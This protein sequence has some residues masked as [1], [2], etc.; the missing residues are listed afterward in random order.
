MK[1]NLDPVIIERAAEAL[2]VRLVHDCGVDWS[3]HDLMAVQTDFEREIRAALQSA[4]PEA[5][6]EER[7]ACAKLADDVANG[8][9]DFDESHCAVC[10]ENIAK[11]IRARSAATMREAAAKAADN[12]L[13]IYKHLPETSAM[14][15]EANETARSVAGRVAAAIRALPL[16]PDTRDGEIAELRAALSRAADSINLI[17]TALLDFA[18]D[19]PH[20]LVT[21]ACNTAECARKEIAEALK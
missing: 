18:G 21:V 11:E 20:S 6:A 19:D 2:V 8:A 12:F 10:A 7:E 5:V 13:L 4:I 17:G 9:I 15:R 3:G 16:P 1:T 14:L